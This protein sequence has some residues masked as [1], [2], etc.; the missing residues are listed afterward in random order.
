MIDRLNRLGRFVARVVARFAEE[1]L[2]QTSASLAYTT[3]LSIVPLVA[4]VLG[5]MSAMPSFLSMVDQLDSTMRNLLPEH[6]ADLII[7]YVLDFSAKAR[8]V[9]IA[10][11]VALIVTVYAM[12]NTVENALNKV[13]RVPQNRSWWRRFALYTA[14]ILLWP[15]VFAYVVAA[16]SYA[17][18]LS[19]GLVF[20]QVWLQ[21]LLSKGTGVLVAAIFFGGLYFAVPNARVRLLDALCGGFFAAFG[22]LLMQRAF[23][24]YLSHFPSVT[25]VYGAFAT[26]PIF[27]LWLYLSWAV[28]LLGALVVVTRHEFRRRDGVPVGYDSV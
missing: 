15:L 3:L 13:W 20:E 14:L 21:K 5:A 4:V 1:S 2:D 9:T 6:S 16:V 22:L 19:S 23:E 10:G 25:L 12:L 26:V 7:K 11:L 24:L 8:K 18:S 27:L 28:V 17:V